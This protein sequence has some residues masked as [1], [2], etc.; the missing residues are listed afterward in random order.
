MA[1]HI[2]YLFPQSRSG[3]R[4]LD[5]LDMHLG[6][7]FLAQNPPRK[8]EILSLTEPYLVIKLLFLS[9]RQLLFLLLRLKIMSLCINLLL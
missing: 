7:F 4:S 1:T 6:K 2:I 3:Q 8:V 5:Y 9:I